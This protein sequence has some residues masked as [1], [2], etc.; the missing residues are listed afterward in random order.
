MGRSEER[1]QHPRHDAELPIVLRVELHGFD[2]GDARFE[3]CGRSR[4]VSRGGLLAWVDREVELGGRIIAHFPDATGT[5][6]RT[7]LFGTVRRCA[8]RGARWEVAVGFDTPLA[9]LEMSDQASP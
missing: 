8:P 6:G 2:G 7:I 9:E 3:S 4:N 5:L 1:R